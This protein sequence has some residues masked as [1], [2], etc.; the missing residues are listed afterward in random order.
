MKPDNE[1]NGENDND[2]EEIEAD[3][4]RMKRSLK[5]SAWIVAG[6]VVA[7]VVVFVV[8]RPAPTVAE[9]RRTELSAPRVAETNGAVSVP[10]VRFTDI[11]ADAG[12]AFIHETGAYGEKLLPETMGGGVAFLDYDGDGDA[13]LLF[14]NGSHWPWQAPE[15]GSPSRPSGL[16]LYRNDTVAGGPVRF[17]DVTKEAGLSA[18]FYGMGIAVGDYDNDGHADIFVTGVGGG[19]LYRN[20]GD[21]TFQDVTTQ[22][23]VGGDASE[24]STASVWFDFDRDGLL[25]LYV[26]SYVKWSREIDAEVGYKIDGTTRAYGPPMNFQGAHPHLYRNLGEGRFEEVTESAGLQVKNSSTGVPLAKTLG[27]AAVDANSDGWVDLV[28]ANDTVQNLLFEN[29][30]DGTFKEVGARVGVA[31]NAYGHTRGAMGIDVARFTDD[32]SLGIAI[33]NFANEMNALYVAQSGKY[34]FTDDAIPWGIGP[35]SRLL[36]KFGIFFFDY[37]LD[38]RLDVLTVNGHIEEEIT[39][40]QASQSYRQPAQLFWNAG[41]AGFI[42]VSI[43]QAGAHLFKPLV[44]R[45]SAYADI[46]GDGDLDVIFTQV[47]GPPLLL[48]N[49]QDL[50]HQSLRLRLV[51][52]ESNR[53][54]QGAEVTV[55]VD[56]R[57]QWR[58]VSTTRSYLSSSER[59]LTFGLGT[60]ALAEWVEVR[61]PSG[62]TQRFDSVAAG[63]HMLM[64]RPRRGAGG[65]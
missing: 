34:L 43:D 3:D 62:E 21:G 1:S 18:P 23:G 20:V 35:A 5:V 30:G 11:T 46:D 22:A 65:D 58:T 37:D 19:R 2:P 27:V 7:V 45:G 17:T 51:G 24:W 48:R 63:Q 6:L 12:I 31:F 29:Q 47:G 61:W 26:G 42:Q 59:V 16:V 53:D 32:G 50:K 41:D 52:T 55:S 40:V 39:K 60:N 38:G 8:R 25:D 54:A 28:V 57:R 64:E 14:V 10:T 36:L 44:G 56:G 49:D 15:G 13:D 33:A 9:D 4:A